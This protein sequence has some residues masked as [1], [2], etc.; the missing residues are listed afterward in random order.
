MRA[1][2]ALSMLLLSFWAVPGASAASRS[3]PRTLTCTPRSA[4]GLTRSTLQSQ[5]AAVKPLRLGISLHC[6]HS[7]RALALVWINNTVQGWL[8]AT[9]PTS[10]L[11]ASGRAARGAT[12]TLA[13]SHNSVTVTELRRATH[14]GCRRTLTTA[15]AWSHGR[16]IKRSTRAGQKCPGNNPGGNLPGE[17]GGKNP[18][19]KVAFLHPPTLA[20]QAAVGQTLTCTPGPTTGP[21]A[22]ISYEWQRGTYVNNPPQ[23]IVNS[24]GRA[25]SGSSY[26]VTAADLYS[27]IR[28]AVFAEGG[29]SVTPSIDS[30][31]LSVAPELPVETIGGANSNGSAVATYTRLGCPSAVNGA[32][33]EEVT[34]HVLRDGQAIP[35]ITSSYLTTSADAG[36]SFSCALS[37]YANPEVVEEAARA[38]GSL[39]QGA[40]GYEGWGPPT[41]SVTVSATS[42]NSIVVAP[43]DSN[44]APYCQTPTTGDETSESTVSTGFSPEF[45][46]YVYLGPAVPSGLFTTVATRDPAGTTATISF[47]VEIDL[48]EATTI[49]LIAGYSNLPEG[50][51]SSVCC[52]TEHYQ[53]LSLTAGH[54]VLSWS[55][56]A[57]VD[58]KAYYAVALICNASTDRCYTQEH[59]FGRYGQN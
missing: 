25:E 56:S 20:G 28:C 13:T 35:G 38:H 11:L 48:T 32:T 51:G 6:I 55:D 4:L 9:L 5:H 39:F 58:P 52:T 15:Y 50:E 47:Q 24:D 43:C 36:H 42:S 7:R 40:H 8:A 46:N 16:L 10:Q 12:L 14:D 26:T 23:D 45:V 27:A 37:A 33:E 57:V 59:M 1:L 34:V 22:R 44:Q 31:P 21:V 17:E 2:L 18:A 29:G 30:V 49:E 19:G 53:S 41:P 3:S 54:H